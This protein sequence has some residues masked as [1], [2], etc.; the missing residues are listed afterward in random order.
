KQVRYDALVAGKVDGAIQTVE[1][2]QRGPAVRIALR[3]VTGRA[4]RPAAVK[5]VVQQHEALGLAPRAMDLEAALRE[6]KTAQALQRAKGSALGAARKLVRA[7]VDAFLSNRPPRRQL[8]KL[9][10][11]LTRQPGVAQLLHEVLPAGRSEFPDGF[12]DAVLKER[13]DVLVALESRPD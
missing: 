6:P 2:P 13:G 5:G 7:A 3:R 9:G 4:R 11:E 12:G 10:R 1:R 8:F